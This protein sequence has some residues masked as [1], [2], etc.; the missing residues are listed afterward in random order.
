MKLTVLALLP[1]LALTDVDGGTPEAPFVWAD[2]LYAACPAADAPV[3]LDGGTWLLSDARVRRVE[4]ALVS[5]DVRRRELATEA[6]VLSPTSQLFVWV[7]FGL[8]LLLGGGLVGWA[9]ARWGR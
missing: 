3:Q 8:G 5:C 6:P 1:H 4:C 2:A 7:G 9:W